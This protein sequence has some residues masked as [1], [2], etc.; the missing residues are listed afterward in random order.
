VDLILNASIMVRNKTYYLN[1]GGAPVVFPE[2]VSPA[3]LYD[4]TLRGTV[5]TA[6]SQ[7][8]ITSPVNNAV[9]ITKPV[10]VVL[11]FNSQTNVRAVY[12]STATTN[13]NLKFILVGATS[14]AQQTYCLTALWA[15]PYDYPDKS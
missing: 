2:R 10:Y 9:F 1:A 3:M 14:E 4:Y 5:S 12:D 11:Q 8:S 7:A 15:S 6:A 13:S